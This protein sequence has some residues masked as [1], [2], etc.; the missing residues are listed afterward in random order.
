[1][2]AQSPPA[3]PRPLDGIRVLDL[4]RLLPGPWATV[5]LADMGAE[6]IKVEAPGG[7]D[8]VRWMPPMVGEMGAAF[9]TLNRG[10]RSVV[11]DLKRPGGS[12]VLARLAQ[13]CD[14]L[15]EGF[16]PGVL[17]RLGV[18]YDTL[19]AENPGLIYCSI[20]GYGAQSLMR[21][22]AGH[23]VCYAALGGIL[24]VSGPADGPPQLPGVQIAD[25]GG[26]SLLAVNA[27]LGALLTRHRTGEG[28]HLDISLAEGAL[29]FMAVP[30]SGATAGGEVEPRGLHPLAGGLV[31]YGIYKTKCG[32][33]VALG[34]LE[35]HFWAAFLAAV[36]RTDLE[37]ALTATGEERER[38]RAEVAALMATRTRDEWIA[39][40]G[41]HDFCLEP[42]LTPEEV[43]HHPLH[44]ARGMFRG[45]DQPGH[46]RVEVLM[47]PSPFSRAD[48]PEEGEA[49]DL[50][51]AP[52]L[53]EHTAEVLGEAG[54][55]DDEIAALRREGVV[56]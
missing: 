15:V 5:M 21:D 29:A 13:G 27:I 45:V 38:A 44:R 12:G 17:D 20:S 34:T 49:P 46:G 28:A 24:G 33:A 56:A 6:I 32:G 26:G 16:R 54:F 8:F 25:I 48:W 2:R 18:G 19:R 35:P 51:P 47:T 10:K 40:A 42:V 36:E 23:D 7:G 55:T 11:V 22:R 1:M 39:L 31:N 41:D 14:V 37:G 43:V 9:V 30:I 50:T 3:A 4:T 52:S 53:G